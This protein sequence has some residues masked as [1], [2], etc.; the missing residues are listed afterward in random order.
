MTH[1]HPTDLDPAARAL[2]R[3]KA[4]KLAASRGFTPSEADDLEQELALHAHL[5]SNRF[6]PRR[7][8]ATAFYDTVLAN[9]VRS[10]VQHAR[11]GKRDRRR[12]RPLDEAAGTPA[13]SQSVDLQL[14]VAAAL[15]SLPA[16][17]RAIAAHLMTGI[18]TVAGVTRAA[19]LTRQRVRS[20][21]GRIARRLAPLA[22]TG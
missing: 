7:G 2:I 15:T 12:E 22:P 5:A 17:D 20:A 21:R 6:D 14:D 16:G 10:I 11:A 4:R 3:H 9:K 1:P 18:D 19:G 8:S 13:S